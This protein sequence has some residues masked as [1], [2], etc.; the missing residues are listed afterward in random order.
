MEKE[1]L[2]K[3]VKTYGDYKKIMKALGIKR[4]EYDL[5]SPWKRQMFEKS[6]KWKV[7]G[8]GWILDDM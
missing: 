1:N 3:R 4:K 6:K 8:R 7:K 5:V 2:P